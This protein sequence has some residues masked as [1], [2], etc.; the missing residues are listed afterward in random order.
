MWVGYDADTCEAPPDPGTGKQIG[1]SLVKFDTRVISPGTPI[2]Q[3]TLFIYLAYHCDIPGY[4]RTV[5]LH[6]A[7]SFWSADTV[8]W[9]TQ[10]SIGEA[11]SSLTLKPMEERPWGWYAFDV[12]DVVQ[13]WVDNDYLNLG[14]AIRGPE[15]S[16][17]DGARLGFITS[18]YLGGAY[19]P[20]ILFSNDA[21]GSAADITSLDLGCLPEPLGPPHLPG[22]GAQLAGAGLCSAE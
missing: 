12:T 7:T 15:G 5:T 13:G 1:R 9:T 11:V 10:P 20:R 21:R 14:L 19:A 17:A 8:D 18:D 6:R 22:S 4:S 2:P 3:A 16:G